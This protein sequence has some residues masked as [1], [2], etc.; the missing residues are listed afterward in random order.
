MKTGIILTLIIIVSMTNLSCSNKKTESKPEQKEIKVPMQHVRLLPVEGAYNVRDLGGY[1][2]ANNKTVKWGKVIRSGDL[3]FLTE[4][5]LVYMSAIPLKTFIDFR[6]AEEVAHAQDKR[7]SSLTNYYHLPIGIGTI[8]D[9]YDFTNIT[10]ETAPTFLIDVYKKIIIDNQEAY[11]QFFEVLQDT[12]KTPLLF[13]CSAGKDRTGLGAALFLAS[14]GVDR[15]TIIEDYLLSNDYLKDKYAEIVAAYPIVKPLMEVNRGYIEAA[16]ETIDSEFG[17]MDN[18]LT[19]Y[20][21]VDIQ[22]MQ[23]LYTE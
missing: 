4:N 2:A 5:D 20:L 10:A 6:D 21:G 13:H 9:L 7:P 19:K 22:K 3:N 8:T 16:F 18:Y 17:G 23:E 1:T 14:L 15:E 12:E 11:L